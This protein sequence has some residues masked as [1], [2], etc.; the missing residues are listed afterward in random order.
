MYPNGIPSPALYEECTFDFKWID[1][2]KAPQNSY[3]ARVLRSGS[4]EDTMLKQQA[5]YTWSNTVYS[6]MTRSLALKQ[7]KLIAIS[8]VQGGFSHL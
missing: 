7:D 6:Y 1:L 4:K 3:L 8:G 2:A 5:L